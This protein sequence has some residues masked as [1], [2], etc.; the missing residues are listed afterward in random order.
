MRTSRPRRLSRSGERTA[1]V[2]WTT[3][4][5]Q[6]LAATGVLFVAAVAL[7]PIPVAAATATGTMGVAATVQAL[8]Q[9]TASALAFGTYTGVQAVAT[10]TITVTCTNTT[11]YNVGLNA[12]TS[13]GATVAARKMT[14]P[15]GALLAYILTSDAGYATN[16]G[17]TV[18]TDTVAGTGNG[19]AQVLTI[20]GRE[21]AGQFLAPGAYTDT[22]TA[23]VTY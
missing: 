19:A 9:N 3:R 13:S 21:A 4:K 2:S 22:I 15:A 12:G 16:W 10:G 20:Y 8:C 14:G 23:T 5:A 7:R 11:P 1:V 17:S 6:L 18:G